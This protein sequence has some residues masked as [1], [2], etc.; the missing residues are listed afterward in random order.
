L[1]GCDV[2]LHRAFSYNRVAKISESSLATRKIFSNSELL[3]LK[4]LSGIEFSTKINRTAVTFCRQKI[5]SHQFN[6]VQQSVRQ[7]NSILQ[8]EKPDRPKR[9]AR[10]WQQPVEKRTEA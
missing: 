4:E 1:A 7:N 9:A 2:S 8:A 5:S 3:L 10:L 6:Y